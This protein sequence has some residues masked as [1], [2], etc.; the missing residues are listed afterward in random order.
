MLILVVNHIK[1]KDKDI[2]KHFTQEIYLYLPLCQR[3]FCS[4]MI[5]NT[6]FQSLNLIIHIE[7][8]LYLYS[9]I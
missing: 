2:L 6:K 8:Y 5:K 9:I 1:N 3:N 4:V 7:I